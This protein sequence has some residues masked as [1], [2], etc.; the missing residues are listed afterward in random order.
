MQ[1]SLRW[2]A[3]NPMTTASH[4]QPGSGVLTIES[5][6]MGLSPGAGYEAA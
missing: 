3:P 5:V 2:R 4:I 6:N 1:T